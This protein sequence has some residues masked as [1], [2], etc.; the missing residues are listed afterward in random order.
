MYPV[1]LRFLHGCVP[2]QHNII[3][4]RPH[5]RSKNQ[6]QSITEPTMQLIKCFTLSGQSRRRFLE[7]VAAS[8][9]VSG[10]IAQGADTNANALGPMPGYSPQMDTLS[11]K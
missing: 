7:A 1:N 6:I 8:T 5:A 4:Q 2:P 3:C 10:R 11:L 9:L